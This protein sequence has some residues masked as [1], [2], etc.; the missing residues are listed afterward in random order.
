MSEMQRS[1]VAERPHKPSGHVST[2][3]SGR[4]VPIPPVQSLKLLEVRDDRVVVGVPG[5]DYKLEL[6]TRHGRIE[7]PVG[8]RIEASIHA[9]AKRIDVVPAGG[10]FVEPIY[11]QPRRV[12]GRIAAGDLG[13]NTL[14]VLAGPTITVKVADPRQHARDFA[15]GQLVSFD[16]E[17]GAEL[18]YGS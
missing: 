14:H 4:E 2:Q 16:V 9:K 12:Q 10:R 17:S 15:V 11:G 13:T 6:M 1:T 3:T 18:R 8:R 5:F 7:T